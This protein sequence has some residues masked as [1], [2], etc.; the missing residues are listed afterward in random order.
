[1]G[2]VIASLWLGSVTG[3]VAY[4]LWRPRNFLG[5]IPVFVGLAVVAFVGFTILAIAAFEW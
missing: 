2:D 4:A 3:A 1:M 5:Y